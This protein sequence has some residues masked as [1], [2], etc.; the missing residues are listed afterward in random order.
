MANSD[1]GDVELI[2]RYQL[3]SSRN[4]SAIWIAGLDVKSDTGLGPYEVAYDQYGVAQKD[5]TGSGFW[6]VEPTINVLFPSDPVVLFASVGYIYS[7]SRTFN[8]DITPNTE[9]QRVN[10]GGSPVGV[11]GFAFA[12]NDRFS[13]SLGYK[14]SYIRPT[15]TELNGVWATSCRCRSASPPSACPTGSPR[16]SISATT[17]SSASRATRRTSTSSPGCRSSSEPAQPFPLAGKGQAVLMFTA[18]D[19]K[20]AKKKIEPERNRVHFL[21]RFAPRYWA[22]RGGSHRGEHGQNTSWRPW[23]PWRPGVVAV[24]LRVNIIAACCRSICDPPALRGRHAG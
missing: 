23:R 24:P 17:S 3:N 12:L 18:K 13:F 5:S 15:Q 7:I 11:V 6:S 19:A 4:N 20:D 14:H 16:R 21:R 1:I 9:V 8:R 10:P 2:A 22:R